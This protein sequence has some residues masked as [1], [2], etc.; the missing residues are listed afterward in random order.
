MSEIIKVFSNE[1]EPK[2]KNALKLCLERI[3]DLR[4]TFFSGTDLP[5]EIDN[6]SILILDGNGSDWF[7]IIRKIKERRDLEKLLIIGFTGS[8]TYMESDER[9]NHVMLSKDIGLIIDIVQ[10]IKESFKLN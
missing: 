5:S 7:N 6:N 3:N 1:D 2:Y 4:V 8:P 9:I 10:I